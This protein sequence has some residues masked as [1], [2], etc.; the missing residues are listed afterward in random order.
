MFVLLSSLQLTLKDGLY[1]ALR[2]VPVSLVLSPFFLYSG[3]R[4]ILHFLLLRL[5]TTKWHLLIVK[6]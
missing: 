6:L 4:L 2:F 3:P 1:A 5:A